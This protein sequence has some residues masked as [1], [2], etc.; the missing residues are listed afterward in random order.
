MAILTNQLDRLTNQRFGS[1]LK[2]GVGV[3][4]VNCQ[5][6]KVE[7]QWLGVIMNP[8]DLLRLPGE[9]VRGVV[10]VV[11]PRH[12]HVTPEVIAPTILLLKNM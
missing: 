6:G 12:A 11:A 9:D 3:S 4:G 8:D 2:G 7:E 10:T 5:V 1:Y